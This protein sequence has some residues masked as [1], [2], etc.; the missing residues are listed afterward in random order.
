MV[1]KYGK[2]V[3]EKNEI[4]LQVPG[5][6]LHVSPSFDPGLVG[7]IRKW[8]E[9]YYTIQFENYPVT[10]EYLSGGGTMIPCSKK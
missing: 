4:R 8:F 5:N 6:T 3:V 10:D 1:I 2:V 7:G 9:S